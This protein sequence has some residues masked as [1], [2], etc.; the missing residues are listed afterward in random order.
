DSAEHG[1]HRSDRRR[2]GTQVGLAGQAPG[3]AGAWRAWLRRLQDLGVPAMSTAPPA[4]AQARMQR[5]HGPWL[6]AVVAAGILGQGLLAL[7]PGYFSHDE[8]QWAAFGHGE[9]ASLGW[10]DPRDL[11]QLQYRPLT[12]NLWLLLGNALFAHPQAFHALW[13]ALGTA[14]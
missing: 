4:G 13:V 3:R 5:G 8:L 1:G 14:N 2:A 6:L 9:L 11:S 10:V 12:F 7:N